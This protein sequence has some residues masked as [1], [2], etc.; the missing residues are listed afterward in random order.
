MKFKRKSNKKGIGWRLRVGAGLVA[1]VL[2][3]SLTATLL[4]PGDAKAAI[5]L[6]GS[7]TATTTLGA[8]S[9]TIALSKPAAVIS[10]SVMVVQLAFNAGS[11]KGTTY[12]LPTGWVQAS[13]NLNNGN[14]YE[15]IFWKVAGASEPS[16]YTF[17]LSRAS[18]IAAG[19]LAYS[20][21]D[22][23]TPIDDIIGYT[24]AATTSTTQS[25]PSASA[26][27][28]GDLMVNFWGYLAST[29]ATSYTA[30]LAA[31]YSVSTTNVG[32]ASSQKLLSNAGATGI[33]NST[34]TV[35]TK[36]LSHTVLLLPSSRPAGVSL[37]AARTVSCLACT[38][39]AAISPAGI[40]AGDFLITSVLWNTASSLTVP[41]ATWIQIGTTITNGLYNQAD[42]YHI[43]VAAD[44]TSYTWVLS[45]SSNVIIST[46]AYAGV[47]TLAP[48]DDTQTTVDAGGSTHTAPSVTS[49]HSNDVYVGLW[50]YEGNFLASTTVFTTTLKAVYNTT[51]GS[52]LGSVSKYDSLGN[53]GA[54][55][56]RFTT[57]VNPANNTQTRNTIAL[58]RA[59]ALKPFIPIPKL[60]AP[61]SSSTGQIL[62][63]VFQ[64]KDYLI[65]A[66]PEKYKL[67]LCSNSTCT[68]II[69]TYDQTI[70]QTGWSGQDVLAGTA[71]NGT[72]QLAT[73]T[74]AFYT[75]QTPLTPGTQY[76]WRAYAN[77]VNGGYFT[78]PSNIS[79]FT[80]SFV[81]LAPT[82][83]SP[84]NGGTNIPL[85]PEFRL[86]ST[87]ADAD[88][89]QYKIQLCSTNTCSIVLYTFDQTVTQAG[90]SGQDNPTF[91][92]Y[93]SDP[94]LIANSAIAYYN[95]T[96]ANL[97]QN[98]TY[99][100]RAYAIDPLGTNTF[101]PASSI[102]TFSTNLTETRIVNGSIYSGRIL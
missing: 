27:T 41:D 84:P 42:Y 60:Y 83:F 95:F 5:T 17:T 97:S 4:K 73:S 47:D 88:D 40:I 81:P 69:S 29:T 54:S 75:M 89:L 10:G 52:T 3:A 70:T 18:S 87:D 50:G 28:N 57:S 34:T 98:T 37:V 6:L 51:D 26:S 61:I 53:A 49:T 72:S 46:G 2:V 15:T 1:V 56:T 96:T 66:G 63:T 23:V 24:S 74:M 45:A 36:W 9:T 91:T 102:A 30:T 25:A 80:T 79:T 59:I 48:I 78:P 82:L 58:M 43:S 62:Y 77:D 21:V 93:G 71:Y 8:T 31:N 100:W 65:N 101:S 33:F 92:A 86:A 94:L 76:W 20:G 12:T 67:D 32:N 44:P 85:H 14:W 38:S 90:W 55:G 22:N 13:T 11:N 39:Q 99:Y 16:S 68:T 35:S 64:L 19:I 7:N